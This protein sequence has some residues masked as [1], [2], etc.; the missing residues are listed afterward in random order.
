MRKAGTVL[1][2]SDRELVGDIKPVGTRTSH[3][4][5]IASLQCM[6]TLIVLMM[7]ETVSRA[8]E[9]SVWVF[10]NIVS[11]EEGTVILGATDAV[12]VFDDSVVRVALSFRA[13]NIRSAPRLQRHTTEPLIALREARVQ[14]SRRVTP[15][16]K[17]RRSA[18]VCLV[19]AGVQL[20]S[21]YVPCVRFAV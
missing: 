5:P 15:G 9:R 17:A 21:V 2:R 8:T 10:A 7:N 13:G 14:Q 3:E 6:P 1:D 4:L 16:L 12:I 11:V 20:V 19:V 18:I